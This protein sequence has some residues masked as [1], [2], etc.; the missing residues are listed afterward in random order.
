MNK[1]AM[2]KKPK[3]KSMSAPTQCSI[4]NKI[5]ITEIEL[6]TAPDM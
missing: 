1:N 3:N 5:A 4:L 6:K 2:P